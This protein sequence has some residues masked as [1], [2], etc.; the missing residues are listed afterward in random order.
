MKIHLVLFSTLLLGS[1][2]AWTNPP[3]TNDFRIER[4]WFENSKISYTFTLKPSLLPTNFTW[5]P[6]SQ[7]YPVNLGDQVA[8]GAAFVSSTQNITNQLAV[9]W[10]RLNRLNIPRKQ[11]ASSGFSPQQVENIWYLE[12]VFYVSDWV[13][14]EAA[15]MTTPTY[16]PVVMFMDGTYANV[17]TNAVKPSNSPAAHKNSS[18]KENPSLNNSFKVQEERSN[19][20]EINPYKVLLKWDFPL[21]AV[22]WDGFK[23]PLPRDFPEQIAHAKRFLLK[24]GVKSDDLVLNQIEL[25]PIGY[26]VEKARRLDWRVA[27][28][29]WVV[30]FEFYEDSAPVNRYDIY[31]LLDGRIIASSLDE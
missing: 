11:L 14:N 6:E 23:E 17:Q 29:H 15:A 8:K 16:W 30:K 18:Q 13:T 2:T 1:L 4:V 3:G 10:L 31:T 5:Q 22:L 26:D 28:L 12:A 21:S 19:Q 7:P 25:S 24:K 27:Q 20:C 9:L